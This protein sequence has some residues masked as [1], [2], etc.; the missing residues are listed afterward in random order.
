MEKIVSEVLLKSLQKLKGEQVF[1]HLE[2]NPGGY[3]RNG[4]AAV[5][6]VHVKGEGHYRVY[7]ELDEKQAIIHVDNLT[8][9]RLSNDE[10]ILIGYDEHHR[11]ARTLEISSKPFA[12]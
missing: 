6:D 7:L 12:I 4:S 8:H 9:M 2:V 11:L 1:I 10:I 5:Y 3:F